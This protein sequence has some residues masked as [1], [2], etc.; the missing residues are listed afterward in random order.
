MRRALSGVESWGCIIH[1]LPVRHGLCRWEGF[2]PEIQH[3]T[4]ATLSPIP[5][6]WCL[7]NPRE[8][9]KQRV[10][11]LVQGNTQQRRMLVVEDDTCK[12]YRCSL[13][14]RFVWSGMT[15]GTTSV[16]PVYAVM[17]ELLTPRCIS[18]YI[19]ETTAGEHKDTAKNVSG[20]EAWTSFTLYGITFALLQGRHTILTGIK[21]V[22]KLER[23][24]IMCN[25]AIAQKPFS[26]L[27]NIDENASRSMDLPVHLP[28]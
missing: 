9:Y 7:W 13:R 12:P 24:Y 20:V 23:S 22:N 1:V 19:R 10:R 3:G 25:W 15:A 8:D 26:S 18:I 5:L 16:V 11:F 28:Q 6:A 21:V 4:L 27:F 14:M 2:T 17:C